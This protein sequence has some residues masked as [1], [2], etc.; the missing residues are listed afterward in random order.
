MEYLKIREA[1][2]SDM[3]PVLK[4]CQNTFSWG[5]YVDHVWNF[6]L[7]EGHLFLSEKSS[8][9]G[10][11]HAFY[12]ENQAWIEGIRVDSNFRHQKIASQLVKH[13]ENIGKDLNALSSYM[14]IDI[15]NAASLS[16]SNSLDYHVFQNW[17]FYSLE[18]K[19]APNY[20][21]QFE[22]CLDR[23]LY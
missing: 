15:E 18:P 22:K 16:M 1:N 9:I 12:S 23:Q 11:C 4:F 20:D 6:W 13:A 7:D 19:V 2:A 8:P 5:D 14:L 3:K 10:I 21:V 17:N